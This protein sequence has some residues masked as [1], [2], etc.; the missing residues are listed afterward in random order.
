MIHKDS[1]SSENI[2][3]LKN[4]KL[5]SSSRNKQQQKQNETKQKLT[6]NCISNIPHQVNLLNASFAQKS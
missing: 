4:R 1:L 3:V 2:F 5:N 6:E